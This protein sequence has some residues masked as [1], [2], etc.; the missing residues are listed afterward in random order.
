MKRIDKSKSGKH[1]P[2][3]IDPKE[4]VRA[5][6]DNNLKRIAKQREQASKETS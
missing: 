1:V 4:L 5:M 3:P 2:I 6:R